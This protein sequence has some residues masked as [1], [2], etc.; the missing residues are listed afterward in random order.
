MANRY[1]MITTPRGQFIY[2]HLTT[3]D[4]KFVKPDGEYHTKFALPNDDKL[5]DAFKADLDR[6][7]EEYI[8]ENPDE[9]KPAKL[10][11]AGRADCYE[12]E[13]DD[14]GEETGRVIFKFSSDDS[15]ITTWPPA[16]STRAASSVA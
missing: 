13:L 9:L 14:E 12:D 7:M 10:K 1:P 8:E 6:L 15:T 16:L 2:P 5:T 4:T 3:P 11:K